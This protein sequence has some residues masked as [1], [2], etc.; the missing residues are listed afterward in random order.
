M[1]E[2]KEQGKQN[3]L[4]RVIAEKNHEQVIEYDVKED[5]AVV[6]AVENDRF[7]VLFDVEDYIQKNRYGSVFID[8]EDRKVFRRAVHTCLQ[9]E[10]TVMVDVRYQ[11]KDSPSE[12][13][14]CYLVSIAGENGEI[15]RMVGRFRNIQQAAGQRLMY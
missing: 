12:W 15:D 13:Y 6:Y 2:Q 4:L 11:G 3:E 8:P 5:H 1:R 9:K 14:S 7:E 10:G